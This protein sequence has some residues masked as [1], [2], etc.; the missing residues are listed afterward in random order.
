MGGI[1]HYFAGN[2]WKSTHSVATISIVLSRNILFINIMDK[3]SRL[4]ACSMSRGKDARAMPGDKGAGLSRRER[5][6]DRTA[7]RTSN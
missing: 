5:K 3:L 6:N 4:L 2:V 1:S 7:C